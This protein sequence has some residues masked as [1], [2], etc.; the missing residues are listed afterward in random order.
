M[1]IYLSIATCFGFHDSYLTA[2]AADTPPTSKGKTHWISSTPFEAIRYINQ[3]VPGF[4]SQTAPR[5]K[6]WP[7]P[8][9]QNA[10]SNH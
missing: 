10:K 2:P 4:R 5:T 3:L 1:T 9:G 8:Q 6:C 7:G